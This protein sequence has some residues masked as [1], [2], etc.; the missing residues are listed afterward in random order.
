M[1]YISADII[2]Y[3]YNN[4]EERDE[5]CS[6]SDIDIFQE[7]NTGIK[8]IINKVKINKAFRQFNHNKNKSNIIKLGRI[9]TEFNDISNIAKKKTDNH[10][11]NNIDSN[12][13]NTLFNNYNHFKINKNESPEKKI[14][15]FVTKKNLFNEK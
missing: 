2:R 3:K 11:L 9:F 4:L 15:S 1:N 7:M 6:I 8:S 10:L 12:K 5:A 14:Y 13:Y